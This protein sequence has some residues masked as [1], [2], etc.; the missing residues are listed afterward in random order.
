MSPRGAVRKGRALFYGRVVVD[1]MARGRYFSR[2]A[3]RAAA[4]ALETG[5]KG[6]VYDV[7]LRLSW[8]L[9]QVVWA[10]AS[11]IN[12]G[13]LAICANTGSDWINP[14]HSAGLYKLKRMGRP[15]ICSA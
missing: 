10:W 13:P 4:S 7:P 14:D 2:M 9:I 6:D 12:L 8:A 3:T 1:A 11:T 5:G 15:S